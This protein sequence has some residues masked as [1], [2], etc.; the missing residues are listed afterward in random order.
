MKITRQQMNKILELCEADPQVAYLEW[1]QYADPKEQFKDALKNY[2]KEQTKMA[3]LG[4]RY[5]QI[6][7]EDSEVIASYCYSGG[8]LTNEKIAAKFLGFVDKYFAKKLHWVLDDWEIEKNLYERKP[9]Y[10]RMF[11]ACPPR[12]DE[13]V[14]WIDIEELCELYYDFFATKDA[15]IQELLEGIRSVLKEKA[16]Q[17]NQQYLNTKRVHHE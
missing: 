10:L 14:V 12:P 5:A 13:N 3:C 15:M 16:R 2:I 1:L 8:P 7:D 6:P 11:C 17:M 9:W 4:G